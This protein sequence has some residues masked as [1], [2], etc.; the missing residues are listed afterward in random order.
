MPSAVTGDGRG[1]QIRVGVAVLAALVAAAAATLAGVVLDAST[2]QRL[3]LVERTRSP[4]FGAPAPDPQPVPTF[5]PSRIRALPPA[6]TGGGSGA[7]EAT[8]PT[9]LA[10]PALDVADAPVVPV[11]I[12][13]TGG[14]EIPGPHEVGWYRYGARPGAGVGSIVLAAHVAYDGEDGVFLRL[15]S[16]E[17]GAAVVVATAD[18][19]RLGYRVDSVVVHRK[20][21]LPIDD[22][23][24]PSSPERLVLITCG[25]TFNPGL[26]HYDSNIVVIATPSPE[27][28]AAG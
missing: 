25:G 6:G 24:T 12:E 14:L 13:P 22:L 16:L 9:G 19:H 26:R 4:A 17:P 5:D 18:G 1:H 23:F 27:A 20:D 28:A 2:P 3:T 10:I 15:G 11:G 8:A 7:T 21:D